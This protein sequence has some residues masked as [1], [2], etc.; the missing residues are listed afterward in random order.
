MA[1]IGGKWQVRTE[2]KERALEKEKRD[3]ELYFL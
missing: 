1:V 3:G 2:K